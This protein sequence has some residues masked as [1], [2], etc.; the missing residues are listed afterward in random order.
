[1]YTIADLRGPGGVRRMW[2]ARPSGQLRIYVDGNTEP[3]ID[4]PAK[5]FFSGQSSP[6]ENPVVGRISNGYYW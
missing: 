2:T 3:L 4:M 1:M 5:T 6:F